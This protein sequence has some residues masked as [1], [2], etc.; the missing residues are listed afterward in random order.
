MHRDT[1]HQKH[2]Q[3]RAQQ[4]PPKRHQQPPAARQRPSL[5]RP[6]Y[7]ASRKAQSLAGSS[8]LPIAGRSQHSLPGDQTRN[9]Q[10]SAARS[11]LPPARPARKIRPRSMLLRAPLQRP[12]RQ[13][14]GQERQ[15]QKSRKAQS[16]AVG[17][18][19][20]LA[21]S[22]R[23][24]RPGY[25]L[26]RALR[27]PSGLSSIPAQACHRLR[28]RTRNAKTLAASSTLPL[29]WLA[30]RPPPGDPVRKPQTSVGIHTLPPA[31]ST[32]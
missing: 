1:P 4:M 16:L 21:R 3:Q 30:R 29:A 27:A 24:T 6:F 11:T 12:T 26:P 9:A 20:P 32:R 13:R 7:A 15:R 17:S 18:T 31:R 23:P 10:T 22:E 8:T 5:D 19:L 2:K 28:S 25:T 14:Y